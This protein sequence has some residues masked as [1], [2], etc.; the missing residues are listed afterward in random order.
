MKYQKNTV[1]DSL[2]GE[3]SHGIFECFVNEEMKEMI[4]EK[5]N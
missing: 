3:Q 4:I 1:L 2:E 5:T